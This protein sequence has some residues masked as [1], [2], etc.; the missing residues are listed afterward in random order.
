MM[1]EW[2]IKFIMIYQ[3][4]INPLISKVFLIQRFKGYDMYVTC[5]ITCW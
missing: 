5:Q 1:I 4:E 3:I 2:F